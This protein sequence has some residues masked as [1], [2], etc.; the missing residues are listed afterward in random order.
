MA[1]LGL[2][3]SYVSANGVTNSLQQ[4]CGYG[5]LELVL[6]PLDKMSIYLHPTLRLSRPTQRLVSIL[7]PL[8]K[9]STIFATIIYMAGDVPTAQ[10]LR[11]MRSRSRSLQRPRWRSPDPTGST[12]NYLPAWSGRSGMQKGS[13]CTRQCSTPSLSEEPAGQRLERTLTVKLQANPQLTARNHCSAPLQ[14]ALSLF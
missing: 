12:P 9:M 14:N 1:R 13:R 11:S 10:H 6:R 4:T 2:N 3:S 7:K 8:V 5:Q